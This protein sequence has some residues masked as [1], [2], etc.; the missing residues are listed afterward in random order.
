MIYD[1]MNCQAYVKASQLDQ[2]VASLKLAV[3]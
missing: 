3:A 1:I 2:M